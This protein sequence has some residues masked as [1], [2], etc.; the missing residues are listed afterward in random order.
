MMKPNQIANS[1]QSLDEQLKTLFTTPFLLDELH[2]LQS[3]AELPIV[4]RMVEPA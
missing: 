2:L 1:K 4:V 3:L